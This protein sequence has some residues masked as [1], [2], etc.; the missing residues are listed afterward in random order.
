MNFAAAIDVQLSIWRV[1]EKV[2]ASVHI[3]RPLKQIK[4][5]NAKLGKYFERKKFNLI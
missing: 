3:F 1:T 5:E 2:R 4:Y